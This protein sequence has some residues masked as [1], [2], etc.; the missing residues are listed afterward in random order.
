M[1][2]Y[3]GR[4]PESGWKNLVLRWLKTRSARSSDRTNEAAAAN[5]DWEGTPGFAVVMTDGP[6]AD[7]WPISGSAFILMYKQ[8]SDSAA[9]GEALKFFAWA[10][11]KGD[12]MAAELD[13]VP[14]PKNV[15]ASIQKLWSGQV[16]DAGGKPIF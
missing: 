5:A 7:S 6:G 4:V 13:Y 14:I 2:K 9:A 1:S 3:S 8:P 12:K 16:K 11:S 15:V 10:Y